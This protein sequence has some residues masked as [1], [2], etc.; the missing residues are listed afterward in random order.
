M[1]QHHD[2]TASMFVHIPRAKVEE[3]KKQMPDLAEAILPEGVWLDDVFIVSRQKVQTLMASHGRKY[4]ESIKKTK[5]QATAETQPEATL[6]DSAIQPVKNFAGAMK[7]WVLNG[8]P[9]VSKEVYES[10]KSICN[11]CPFWDKD[12]NMG[13]GKCKQCGCT[14]A[15]LYLA[16]EKCPIDKWGP[17]PKD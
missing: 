4:I 5:Q 6:D 3:Q 12:G 15:K 8:M 1:R 16:T 2:Q 14:A 13:M 10:R 7:T 9:I 17:A 11:S